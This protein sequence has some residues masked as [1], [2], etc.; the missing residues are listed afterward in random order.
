[1]FLNLILNAVQSMSGGGKLALATGTGEGETVFASV[2]DTGSGIDG[3]DLEHIFD[4]FFTTKENGSGLGLAIV[5]RIVESH[6]GRVEVNSMR[7]KGTTITV[8]L[9]AA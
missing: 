2:A 3:K 7:G 6:K 9:P 4:P 5:Y 1:V 8:A